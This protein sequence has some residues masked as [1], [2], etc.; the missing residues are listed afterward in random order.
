MKPL[1]DRNQVTIGVVGTVIAAM[2][3]LLALNLDNLPLI[4]S[5]ND[6]HAQFENAAGLQAGDDVRVLGVPV[7]QVDSVQVE[8][9]H[10]RVDFHIED[11]VTL[12][13]ASRASIEIATVLGNVY[14]Q[15]ESAGAGT[16]A[17]GGTIPAGR[18]V[19]PYSLV[20]ALQS[21]ASFGNGT[22]TAQ[23]SRSLR[24]L[25]DTVGTIEPS[26]AK[27]ALQGITN[28]ATTFAAK[29]G[30]ITELLNAANSIVGT[31][32]QNSGALVELV[33]QGDSFLKLV[34][35]RRAIISA[36]LRD[37]SA[38]GQQLQLL[39]ERNGAHLGSLLSNLRTVTG[40]LAKDRAQLQ[41]AVQVLGQFSQNLANATGSGPW[42]DL[43]PVTGINPDNQIKACGTNPSS[44][45][46]PCGD[47]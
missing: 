29:Q 39:I 15:I 22:N 12:G 35:K 4:N 21:F 5:N 34:L 25:A 32:N 14:L 23:L 46:R 19:V 41:R 20:T 13:S 7:G 16:L 33:I 24:T 47:H 42:L 11:D 1:K 2:V 30:Q 10:V 9:G 8:G 17:E 38:L 6:Y 44:S 18:T 40:L 43:F 3:V 37:T 27:A 26:D 36:L 28:I 31:L 45:G